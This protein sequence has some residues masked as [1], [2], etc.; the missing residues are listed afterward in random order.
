MY[1]SI[2]R[3]PAIRSISFKCCS[4][5]TDFD[6]SQSAAQV[7]GVKPSVASA[8][9]DL[10]FDKAFATVMQQTGPAIGACVITDQT[11][12]DFLARER[13][14]MKISRRSL[15]NMVMALCRSAIRKAGR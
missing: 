8:G 10:D 9:S 3:C 7:L 11:S 2:G 1:R 6:S 12:C 15:M 5:A 4:K 14:A 13:S